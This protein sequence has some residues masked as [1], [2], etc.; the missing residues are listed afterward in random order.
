MRCKP[1]SPLSQNRIG[2]QSSKLPKL[3]AG[4]KEPSHKAG[5]NLFS[6]SALAILRKRRKTPGDIDVHLN[7]PACR[8][9]HWLILVHWDA[10]DLYRAD[11]LWFRFRIFIAYTLVT[12]FPLTPPKDILCGLLRLRGAR[13][14]AS[15]SN[16][17]NRCC[18]NLCKA[19]YL[20]DP[21]AV[22]A[23][24]QHHYPNYYISL[25]HCLPGRYVLVLSFAASGSGGIGFYQ[26]V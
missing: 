15:R 16:W 21:L 7:G 13:Q 23:R 20:A 4:A 18:H 11:S 22:G 8:A 19:F 3:P 12:S 6:M 25:D 9:K 14:D 1:H 5:S 10:G 17:R 2:Q 26:E 24:L